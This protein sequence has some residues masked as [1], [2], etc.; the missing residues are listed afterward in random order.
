MGRDEVR[1][2]VGREFCLSGVR[3]ICLGGIRTQGSIVKTLG[4]QA[5][6]HVL[7]SGLLLETSPYVR[8]GICQCTGRRLFRY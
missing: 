1:Q 8:L 4:Y 5:R 2:T 6:V 3:R 7:V